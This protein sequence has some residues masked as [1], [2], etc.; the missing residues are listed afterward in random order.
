VFALET[1][2]PGRQPIWFVFRM[3]DYPMRLL[4][5]ATNL[6]QDDAL[7]WNTWFDVSGFLFTIIFGFGIGALT[8]RILFRDDAA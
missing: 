6:L 1:I 4:W 5:N 2:F 8:Y 3:M 7:R